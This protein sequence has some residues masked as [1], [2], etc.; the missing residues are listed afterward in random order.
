[1]TRGGTGGHVTHRRESNMSKFRSSTSRGSAAFDALRRQQQQQHRATAVSPPSCNPMQPGATPCNAMQP[2]QALCKTNPP[3]PP[4]KPEASAPGPVSSGAS[5]PLTPI[6]HFV[7][8]S[9]IDQTCNA[10]Q[11]DATA[12]NLVQPKP[13]VGKTNPPT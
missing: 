1:M 12:C 11:P 10:M 6:T 5:R 9:V 3:P 4:A 7:L 8:Q 13:S 2:K